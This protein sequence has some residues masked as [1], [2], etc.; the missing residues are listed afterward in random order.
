[1]AVPGSVTLREELADNG[2]AG[3]GRQSNGSYKFLA[4]RRYDNLHF[5][6]PFYKSANDITG[7]I[8]GNTACNA[9][10]YFLSFQWVCHEIK[11]LITNLLLGNLA[12]A[13]F[14]QHSLVF[15]VKS[16]FSIQL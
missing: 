13:D 6:A 8:S 1:M 15:S 9:E 10:Y 16:L 12:Q 2:L 3:K 14:R 4:R 7:F 11:L 5:R